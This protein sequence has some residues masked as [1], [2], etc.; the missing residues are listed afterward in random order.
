MTKA[1]WSRRF[2]DPIPLP[3]GSIVRTIGEAAAYTAALPKRVGKAPA[4]QYAAGDLT[5]AARNPADMSRARTSFYNALYS[6]D[7]RRSGEAPMDQN[8]NGAS[9]SG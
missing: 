1:D 4:W 9:P 7:E 5:R 3:D 8:Q 2:D 6:E